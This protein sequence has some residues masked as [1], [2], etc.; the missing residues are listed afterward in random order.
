MTTA[1]G[2]PGEPLRNLAQRVKELAETLGMRVEAFAYLPD[3]EADTMPQD[4][5][6]VMF[7]MDG[8]H[9]GKAVGE[10]SIEHE[11][12]KFRQEMEDAER[13]EAAKEERARKEAEALE[14]I[15]RLARGELPTVGDDDDG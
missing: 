10:L 1:H 7:S 15:Q 2:D 11:L 14:G 4:R 13:V 3:F 12:E 5:I 6:Q 9:V 8:E